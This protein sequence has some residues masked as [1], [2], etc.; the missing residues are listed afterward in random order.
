MQTMERLG[1]Y[2]VLNRAREQQGFEPETYGLSETE[3]VTIARMFTKCDAPR[4]CQRKLRVHESAMAQGGAALEA[5]D[6]GKSSRRMHV[7]Q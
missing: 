2:F 3:A 6:P 5:A 4:P 7:H 1:V